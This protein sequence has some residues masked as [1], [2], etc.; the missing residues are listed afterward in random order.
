[1]N[2]VDTKKMY[3]DLKN[4]NFSDVI[5]HHLFIGLLLVFAFFS[6]AWGQADTMSVTILGSSGPD[7]NPNRFGPSTL[8][9]AGGKS[10]IFDAGRG[11]SIRL[12][13]IGIPVGHVTA[14]FLTHYH[15]DHTNGLP[16]LWLTGW[17]PPQGARKTAFRVI[18]PTGARELVSG[19]KKAYKADLDIRMTEAKL[20]ASGIEINVNEFSSE[21]IVF[22]EDG[23]RVIAIKVDHG[24]GIEPAFGY[25]VIYGKRSVVIS[26]DT[27]FS[28]NLINHSRGVDLLLH[29]VAEAPLEMK[30]LPYVKVILDHH[31]LPEA[32]GR[33]FSEARPKLAA[34]THF[35]LLKNSKGVRVSETDVEKATRSTYEGPLELGLDLTRFSIGDSVIVQRFD[36][37]K[38]S[39]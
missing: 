31:T 20:P 28:E 6:N 25:K 36:F 16:D 19:L 22:E 34:Y 39:Y 14:V 29:E 32:A 15:S 7:P 10:L 9:Q 5:T 23:V 1:M 26:G 37:S 27:K 13:Q 35:V 30:K 21:S 33:I 12:Q 2:S 3:F 18:G 38:G 11:A 8:V 17:L 24:E 4:E